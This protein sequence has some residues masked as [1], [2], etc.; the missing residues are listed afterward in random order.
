[1]KKLKE[2]NQ[3]EGGKIF[4]GDYI[5]CSMIQNSDHFLAEFVLFK[6]GK[7]DKFVSNEDYFKEKTMAEV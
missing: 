4:E 1:M 7:I 3:A 2:E 5:E 6:D